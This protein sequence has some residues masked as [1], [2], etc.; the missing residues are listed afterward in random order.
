[1][2][3]EGLAVAQ[4]RRGVSA[5]LDG[6]DRR[7]PSTVTALWQNREGYPASC[8]PWLPT[9][10][11]HPERL[12][13]TCGYAWKFNV[14]ALALARQPRYCY[15]GQRPQE[16]YLQKGEKKVQ[17]F[18]RNFQFDRRNSC[19]SNEGLGLWT[20]RR[21]RVIVWSPNFHGSFFLFLH[22]WIQ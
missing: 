15:N 4:T 7:K 10:Q 18:P 20:N 12:I 9:L 19:C 16:F 22:T 13:L 8:S 1:M 2:F 3:I 11:I 6:N 5:I 17:A 21:D 14:L